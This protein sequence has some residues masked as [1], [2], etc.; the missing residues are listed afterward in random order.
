MGL[1]RKALIVVGLLVALPN[2]PAPEGGAEQQVAA[3]SL[4]SSSFATFTAAADTLADVKGFC[5]RRP[6]ACITGQYL[7]YQL[8]GKAKYAARLAYQWANPKAAADAT[9]PK[10]VSLPAPKSGAAPLRLATIIDQRPSNIED[11]LRGAAQ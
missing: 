8:E 2:P 9:A 6:Q 5:E 7:A 4:P 1:I 11:L 3:P 10:S